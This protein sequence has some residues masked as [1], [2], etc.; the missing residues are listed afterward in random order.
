LR[1]FKNSSHYAY[2]NDYSLIDLLKIPDDVVKA[3]FEPAEG[4]YKLEHKVADHA[5]LPTADYYKVVPDSARAYL[6][7]E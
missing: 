5:L 2:V 1:T 4:D 6:N 7:K 3:F